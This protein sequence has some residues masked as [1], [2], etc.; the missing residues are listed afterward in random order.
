RRARALAERV[1][2]V[3]FDPHPARVLAPGRAP[4]LLQSPGQRERVCEALGVDALALLPFSPA[5]AA[6]EPDAFVDE[7]LIRGL[8]P[9]AVVVGAAVR[10]GAGGR[11]GINDLRRRLDAAGVPLA[12][13]DELRQP[14]AASGPPIK[15]GSSAIRA[16]VIEGA[17]ASIPA[18]L[19]RPYAVEGAVV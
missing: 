12:V 5:M 7:V 3:T 10:S 2:V 1:A 15:I 17:V 14:G 16:A 9:A 18:L 19:G 13:V 8:G 6:M 4:P 11:G